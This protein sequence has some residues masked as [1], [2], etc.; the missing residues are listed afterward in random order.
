MSEE[1][2]F[3]ELPYVRIQEILDSPRAP[4]LL[5]PVGSTEPHG[6]HSPLATDPIISIGI[7]ERV[8]RG[9]WCGGRPFRLRRAAPR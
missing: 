7:A 8:A 1:L 9:A 3:A 2:F 5:W 4:V 6:P